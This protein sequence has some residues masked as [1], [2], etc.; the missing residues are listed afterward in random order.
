MLK[1][2][3]KL[4]GTKYISGYKNCL[5]FYTESE[6]FILFTKTF[7]NQSYLSTIQCWWLAYNRCIN[8]KLFLKIWIEPYRLKAH[9]YPYGP[10]SPSDLQQADYIAYRQDCMVSNSLLSITRLRAAL[11]GT[12]PLAFPHVPHTVSITG[13][14][15]PVGPETKQCPRQPV[16]GRD[17]GR[18]SSIKHS[19]L[20]HNIQRWALCPS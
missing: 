15:K 18:G 10:L 3:I 2:Y 12:S 6:N 17:G 11:M 5:L 16:K 13:C 19:Y 8:I 20:P 1:G 14:W 9:S 7:Q 4:I